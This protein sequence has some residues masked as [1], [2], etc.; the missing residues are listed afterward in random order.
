MGMIERLE[1]FI[2]GDWRHSTADQTLNVLNPASAEV[3]A[4]VPLSPGIAVHQAAEA[5]ARA[6]PQWRRTPVGERIQPL[7]KLKNLLKEN[8]DDLASTITDECGKTHAESKGE[9][10]R[11]IENVETACGMPT[12]MQGANSE[13]IAAGI[14]EHMIRQPLGVTAP[15][16]TLPFSGWGESFFGDLHAQAHHAAE[17]YTQTKVVVERW[18]KNGS[19]KF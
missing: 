11:A 4:H 8:L 15:M 16:S 13:D 2:D 3:L 12:L 17:F 19:R 6:F 5:A 10:R 1:H 18:P 14:D 9:L 7:F